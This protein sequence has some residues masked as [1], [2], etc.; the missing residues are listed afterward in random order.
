M[1][2][3]LARRNLSKIFHL[4]VSAASAI[5][6]V[7]TWMSYMDGKG[8]VTSTVCTD[9][10]LYPFNSYCTYKY[11]KAQQLRSRYGVMDR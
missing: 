2:I 4:H 8:V 7:V 5:N 1:C 11:V 9:D 3:L 6:G 10:V